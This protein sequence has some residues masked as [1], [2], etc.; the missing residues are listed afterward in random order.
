MQVIFIILNKIMTWHS[1]TTWR[2]IVIFHFCRCGGPSVSV[3]HSLPRSR[4]RLLSVG[5][6]LALL[7]RYE[8]VAGHGAMGW[9]ARP[10]T[11]FFYV[12]Y[13]IVCMLLREVRVSVCLLLFEYYRSILCDLCKSVYSF[14]VSID[15]NRSTIYILHRSLLLYCYCC[16]LCFIFNTCQ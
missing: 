5:F 9:I 12:Q 2:Q 11:T 3:P 15:R 14:C 16:K 7:Q 1:D 4:Q 8:R 13:W 10:A 6:S